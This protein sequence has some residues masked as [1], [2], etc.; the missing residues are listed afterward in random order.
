MPFSF[1]VGAS[2][3]A[4]VFSVSLLKTIKSPF[5]YSLTLI[6]SALLNNS[7]LIF[8][9]AAGW[10]FDSWVN[11][12]LP[13]E[14]NWVYGVVA[15]MMLSLALAPAKFT[16]GDVFE[17]YF[18]LQH[19]NL[20]FPRVIWDVE[21]LKIVEKMCKLISNEIISLLQVVMLLI[22]FAIF[23]YNLFLFVI[24]VC[25]ILCIVYYY[26][27]LRFIRAQTVGFVFAFFGLAILYFYEQELLFSVLGGIAVLFIRR[28]SGLLVGAFHAL[29]GIL[30]QFTCFRYGRSTI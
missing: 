17:G 13:E 12:K 30:F 24:A 2:M 23:S 20:Y 29:D 19:L 28:F 22:G 6:V 14:Y 9:A 18:K 4:W 11:N 10:V 25:I 5:R 15:I 3:N 26:A 1:G 16:K 27:K 21:N 7:T 8:F